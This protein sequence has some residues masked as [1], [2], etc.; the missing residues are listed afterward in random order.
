MI[1]SARMRQTISNPAIVTFF[2]LVK[3]KN[4]FGGLVRESF[5]R[6]ISHFMKLTKQSEVLFDCLRAALFIILYDEAYEFY[7]YAYWNKFDIKLTLNRLQN[8]YNNTLTRIVK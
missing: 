6:K 8:K 5:V 4:K 2:K 1:R 7:H 3:Q